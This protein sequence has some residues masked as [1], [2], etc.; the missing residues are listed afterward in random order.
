MLFPKFKKNYGKN[1]EK[2]GYVPGKY[3]EKEKNESFKKLEKDS[4]PAAL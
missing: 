2:C 1:T 3:K 4:V